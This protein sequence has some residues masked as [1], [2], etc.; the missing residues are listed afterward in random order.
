MKLFTRV[1]FTVVTLF[2]VATG[3]K[4]QA[5]TI[6][7]FSPS[8][9][10]VGTLVT[11]TGT[12]FSIIPANNIVYFGAVKAV[13][14]SATPITLVVVVPNGATYEPITVNVNGLINYSRIPFI[15]TFPGR[16]AGFNNYLFAP[17]IDSMLSTLPSATPVGITK[18]DLNLDGKIDIIT[19]NGNNSSVSIFNNTSS[20]GSISFSSPVNLFLGIST[21]AIASSDLDGDG[22]LDLVISNS[23]FSTLAILKNTSVGSNIAFASP[24]YVT[25]GSSTIDVVIGDLDNDGKEDIVAVNK[26]SNSL[27]FFKNTSTLGTI[28]F[29]SNQQVNVG[30]N[31]NAISVIDLDSDG[32]MDLVTVNSSNNTITVLKNVTSSGVIS[33]VNST[34]QVGSN[35]SSIASGDIDSDGKLDLAI[36]NYN[37]NTV[38][39]F[40]N[41]SSPGSI[42]FDNKIDIATGSS[43]RNIAIADI[44]GDSKVDIATSNSLLRNVTTTSI[45]FTLTTNY[46]FGEVFCFADINNDSKMDVL[47][48]KY[49]APDGFLSISR[50]RVDEPVIQ[51]FTPTAAGEG[52]IVTIQGYNFLGA[53]NVSYGGTT[54]AS[55]T[56]LSDTVITSVIGIGSKGK[57]SVDNVYGRGEADGF[58]YRP[59]INS[60]SPATAV[61]G[62]NINIAG[63]GFRPIAA[64]NIVYFGAVKAVVVAS[65]TTA[66]NVIVP[67]CATY[68]PI[69]V[70]TVNNNLTGYSTRPFGLSFV[71]DTLSINSFAQNIDFT[72]GST[73]I[74]IANGDL[75]NDGKSDLVTVNFGVKFSLSLFRNKSIPGTI[76]L[77]NKQDI[78]TGGIDT[79]SN[80]IR[81]NDLDGDGKLDIVL[82]NNGN[83]P[84]SFNSTFSTLRNTS[85]VDSIMFDIKNDYL[86]GYQSNPSSGA[87]SD[88][89]GDGKP[90]VLVV[91]EGAS[92]ISIFKNTSTVGSISFAAKQDFPLA[93]GKDITINDFN[94][95]NKPDIAIVSSLNSKISILRNTS[96][97]TSISFASKIDYSTGNNVSSNSIFSGD[98]DGDNKPDIVVISVPNY[99]IS[100]YKN[101][102]TIDSIAFAPKI[103]YIIGS[104]AGLYSIRITDLDGDGKP[105]IALVNQGNTVVA[106]KN[107]STLNDI[108][109][110]LPINYVLADVTGGGRGPRSIVLGDLDGDGLPDIATA[111]QSSSTISIL[112]NKKTISLPLNLLTFSA[113]QQNN[114]IALTWQTTNEVNTSFFT[115]QRSVDGSSFS[116]IGKVT[117][118]GDGSYAF[119]DNQLPSASVVYY[120]LQM[121]DKD[122][123]FTYS[124][125]VSCQLS[126][127]SRALT[128]Y[129]NPVKDNLFV[130]I[131]STKA[132]KITLQLTDLQ[133]K[134]LQQEDTQV[135]IGN[136]SLSVNTSAL[137]NGSYVLVVKGSGGVQQKQFVKE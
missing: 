1:V 66:L 87:V 41:L 63:S 74:F 10:A 106:L 12:N 104:G 23:N 80:C 122:G 2:V 15:V 37:S 95:D 32:K 108:V 8:S 21:Q 14:N 39:I 119:A 81:L 67:A 102:S 9:G 115:I 124:K 71:N 83:A 35:P 53:T 7:S 79:G 114:N 56:I 76:N 45:S 47:G 59:V 43:P 28:S 11:I 85:T 107:N 62:S 112:K 25:T 68:G 133:G 129:P 100:V 51:S 105:D 88:I 33:F 127:I 117:A 49:S 16:D 120:R 4:G 136:V 121:V 40:K 113:Q 64:D 109:F 75:N 86:T 101:I 34:Y 111:N 61:A 90:E 82:V 48:A 3:V 103:D 17:K 65:S 42:I 131:T 132:E 29:S 126:G 52:G 6:S 84:T 20:N 19:A 46:N 135:G 134:L 57:V 27:S 72:T 130:Q 98:L 22:K 24:I 91:N 89:D 69:S 78:I 36:A 18:A 60:F 30:V 55:F 50:N 44:D 58:I 99:L 73:P 54:S 92:T 118:K 137:A 110:G 128:V 70:T 125:I 26:T 13:V 116:N 123:S 31:S 5:P 94:G 97:A 77:N 96:S 38:S 93:Y